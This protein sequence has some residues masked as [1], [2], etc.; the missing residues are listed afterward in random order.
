VL[1]SRQLATS[2]RRS[3]LA[4]VTL[5]VLSCVTS[6]A[7]ATS[8]PSLTWHTIETDHFKIT[9]HSGLEDVAQHV[10]N[11]AEGVY[12]TLP[13][14]MGHTPKQKTELLLADFSEAANGSATA[15]PYNAIRLLVTAPEDL[16]PLGDVD[17][18]YLELVT[19]EYT[20]VL[21]TDNIHGIPAI[22]N[23]VVGKTFAP[24]QVQPRWILE[25]IGVHQESARTSAGRLRSSLWDMYMRTDVLEDNVATLDQVSNTVRRWPQGNLFYLYG[26]YFIDWIVDTYGDDALRK[27]SSYHGSQIIPWAINRAVRRATGRT[28]EELYPG[29]IESMK[30]RYAVQA[31]AVRAKGIR[32]GVRLTYHGQIARYPR[33]IPANAWPEHVGS[34]LYYR[35]DQ[36]LRTG[37]WAVDVKRDARGAVV[38]A[39]PNA[40]GKD[41]DLLARTS[42]ES[43]TSF[44]PDGGVVFSSQELHKNVFL[45]GDLE[46]MEPSAKSPYGTPDGG[47]KRITPLGSRAADPTISPDGRHVVFTINRNG[48]RAIHTGDL[49]SEEGVTNVRPLVQTAFLEQAFTPRYSPDGNYV[50]YS[51]WKR[52]GYRDIRLVDVRDGSVREVTIDRAVDGAPCFSPDGKWIFFHSDRTGITNIYAFEVATGRVKQVTNVLTGAFMPDVSPDGRSLAYIG[53]GKAGFD[54]YAMALDENEWPDAPSYVDTHP[55]APPITMKRWTPRPYSLFPTIFPRRYGIQITPG[56]FGQAVIIT[57]SASDLTGFHNVAVSSTTKIEKPE[58]QGL[59]AYTYARLP[60]DMSL[61]V[62]RTITP[63]GGYALGAFRPTVI[64]ENVGFASTIAYN[65]PGAYDTR[66]YV[67]SH[68]VS[69]VGIDLPFPPEKFDPYETPQIPT[70][71]LTS[72]IHLGYSFTNAERY[73]WSVGPERGYSLGVAF[74]WTDPLIASQFTGF[75]SNVDFTTYFLMPWLRNHSVA[76]HGGAGTSGGQFPGRGAFFLGG[77]VDLPLVDRRFH[78]ARDK[79]RNH[80][81]RYAESEIPDPLPGRKPRLRRVK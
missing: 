62:F 44:R 40:R 13:A 36:R 3:L 63:R 17:D 50:V 76:L 25:G 34:I 80:A 8:D 9:Y 18:W 48:T 75:A 69:R 78:L 15:L 64:Q 81:S 2:V 20:H 29:W 72:T 31:D 49:G 65:Q 21:H 23:A 79:E 5:L 14:V 10:A 74:D 56:N 55:S 68:S 4:L 26:S 71:G 67:I 1:W 6:G 11:V 58:L 33:W 12:G 60:F 73:L 7:R 70:R 39:N 42:G 32:E 52:G 47:R 30:K 28:Y 59:A 57:A 37:I 77:Y 45:F 53:Y 22:V 61:S 43:V 38:L 46:Q 24:N 41:A 16:S 35:E 27:I 19:H 54:L 66:G 51:I